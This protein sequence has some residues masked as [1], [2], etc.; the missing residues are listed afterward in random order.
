MKIG[1]VRARA[2]GQHER[3]VSVCKQVAWLRWYRRIRDVQATIPVVEQR[4]W[5]RRLDSCCARDG[6]CLQSI[7]AWRESLPYRYSALPQNWRRNRDR[8]GRSW[9]NTSFD[10]RDL[11]RNGCSAAS[12]WLRLHRRAQ[13]EQQQH[14]QQR[15]AE[16][17]QHALLRG[18][19]IDR[20]R[21]SRSQTKKRNPQCGF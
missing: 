21:G 18:L 16:Q 19:P 14:M 20:G 3:C 12:E 11:H 8:L 17:N 2:A 13:C 7:R 6:D 9:R 1:R 15:D 5:R 4:T 10:N